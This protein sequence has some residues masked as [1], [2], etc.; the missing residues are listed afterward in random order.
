MSSTTDEESAD[1]EVQT[2]ATCRTD[3]ERPCIGCHGTLDSEGRQMYTTYY[4]SAGCQKMD[5]DRT[6]KHVCKAAKDRRAVYRVGNIAQL[7]F[8]A[9]LAKVSDVSITKVEKQKDT[10][11]LRQGK[12]DQNL[13][14]P[15]PDKLFSNEDDKLAALTALAYDNAVGFVQVFIM[16]MLEGA[17]WP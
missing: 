8:F 16:K 11:Y 5:Y 13:I 1:E 3:G 14:L 4:C 2:C 9:Y 17:Y 10:L 6:H 12:N 7:A 15:F